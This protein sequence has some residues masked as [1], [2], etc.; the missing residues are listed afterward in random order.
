METYQQMK[1]RHQD[2]VNELPLIF[3][4]NNQQLEEALAKRGMTSS[5]LERNH[6]V[7]YGGGCYCLKS[8]EA[9]IDKALTDMSAE[10]AEAMK[11]YDFAYGAF[12]YELGNH[13]YHINTYQGDW[14]VFS[15]FGYVEWGGEDAGADH[16]MTELG[17]TDDQKRAFYDARKEFYRQCDENNWW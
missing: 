16:Y 1:Q 5:D 12:L 8:D 10:Q 17:Y 11:D 6:L 3:A 9:A 4:F 2:A 13:E 15:C 7:S 14:D